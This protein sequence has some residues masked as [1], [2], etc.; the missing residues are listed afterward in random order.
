MSD[1]ASQGSWSGIISTLI[2]TLIVSGVAVL[3]I[4]ICYPSFREVFYSRKYFLHKETV[5]DGKGKDDAKRAV[6]TAPNTRYPPPEPPFR[7]SVV[8]ASPVFFPFRIGWDAFVRCACMRS[9][10]HAAVDRSPYALAGVVSLDAHMHQVYLLLATYFFSV[11]FAAVIPVAIVNATSGGPYS[12]PLYALATSRVPQGSGRMWLHWSMM[13]LLTVFLLLLLHLGYLEWEYLRLHWLA[14]LSPARYS[15]LITGLPRKAPPS[16]LRPKESTELRLLSAAQAAEEGR[17]GTVEKRSI[18]QR[19]LSEYRHVKRQSTLTPSAEQG[20][21]AVTT[22]TMTATTAGIGTASLQTP[23]KS[24]GLLTASNKAPNP[25]TVLASLKASSLPEGS[26]RGYRRYL[27]PRGDRAASAAGLPIAISNTPI[28]TAAQAT[29]TPVDDGAVGLPSS[30]PEFD[31]AHI[32]LLIAHQRFCG[33]LEKYQEGYCDGVAEWESADTKRKLAEAQRKDIYQEKY[34]KVDVLKHHRKPLLERMYLKKA[35]PLTPEKQAKR[36]EAEEE[37]TI[38]VALHRISREMR[39]RFGQTQLVRNRY[40]FSRVQMAKVNSG[41]VGGA[42]LPAQAPGPSASTTDVAQPGHVTLVSHDHGAPPIVAIA[43]GAAPATP[44]GPAVPPTS[45]SVAAAPA[46]PKVPSPTSMDTGAGVLSAARTE[47][48]L[49]ESKT[50]PSVEPM[51]PVGSSESV[52]GVA[53]PTAVAVGEQASPPP[54]TP[55]MLEAPDIEAMAKERYTLE[56]AIAEGLLPSPK[57]GH[58]HLHKQK[59]SSLASTPSGATAAMTPSGRP[60]ATTAAAKI[61]SHTRMPASDSSI[62]TFLNAADASQVIAQGRQAFAEG[63]VNPASSALLTAYGLP[64]N[65]LKRRTPNYANMRVTP[66]PEPS[67]LIFDNTTLKPHERV[68]KPIVAY[69]WLAVIIFIASVPTVAAA[70]LS[71]LS[72]IGLVAGFLAPVLAWS[73]LSQGLIQNLIPALIIRLVQI[74]LLTFVTIIGK[75]RGEISLARIDLWATK[76]MW[77]ATFVST[78]IVYSVAS[79]IFGASTAVFSADTAVSTLTLLAQSLPEQSG[80]FIAFLIIATLQGSAMTL[81]RPIDLV[82]FAICKKRDQTDRMLKRHQR[83]LGDR[84]PYVGFLPDSLLMLTIGVLYGL[85]NPPLIVVVFF[86]F[87]FTVGVSSHQLLYVFETPWDSGGLFW[88]TA[89][90][91]TVGSMVFSQAVWVFLFIMKEVQ[92][93]GYLMAIPIALTVLVNIYW[94]RRFEKP[95]A[96]LPPVVALAIQQKAAKAAVGEVGTGYSGAVEEFPFA[97]NAE[98]EELLLRDGYPRRYARI[99]REILERLDANGATDASAPV[100]NTGTTRDKADLSQ[101]YFP[102]PRRPSPYVNP[103]FLH[104]CDPAAGKFDWTGDGGSSFTGPKLRAWLSGRPAPATSVAGAGEAGDSVSTKKVEVE[105]TAWAY[106]HVMAKS[107]TA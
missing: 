6:K 37:V 25:L 5:A 17:A 106:S 99:V 57:H 70:F 58:H 46:S 81:W 65:G 51:K 56:R 27:R 72:A 96:F 104:A 103:A 82:K 95:L 93:A 34:G 24:A 3:S 22:P 26:N 87:I 61:K 62:V 28:D 107:L 74:L 63:K 55:L 90:A 78:I 42:G 101:W 9:R 64:A 98:V 59:A 68:W 20:A 11:F 102:N 13:L 21:A 52:Y 92:V 45:P 2:F 66:A 12:D 40:D 69:I 8:R 33:K 48:S 16:A 4:I 105:T 30:S 44:N 18:S 43:E 88:Q 89:A 7:S 73:G 50:V 41:A 14:V 19:A 31:T 85:M 67:D 35:K 47:G 84:P 76:W 32:R 94:G 71:N 29:P 91:M 53:E 10:L 23:S 38:A 49:V 39:R 60:T 54:S 86:Y 15:V 100:T 80:T 75:L 79:T 36:D 77:V 83:G 97:S 1:D